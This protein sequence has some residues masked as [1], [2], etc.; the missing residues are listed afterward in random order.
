MTD[1]T[2]QKGKG[3]D[4]LA[5]RRIEISFCGFS[6]FKACHQKVPNCECL[7][8]VYERSSDLTVFGLW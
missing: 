7:L 4:F 6:H 8:R 1:N 5:L 3:K 2:G